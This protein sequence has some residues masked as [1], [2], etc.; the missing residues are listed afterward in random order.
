MRI[1]KPGGSLTLCCVLLGLG[2]TAA[3][4]AEAPAAMHDDGPA[5]SRPISGEVPSDLDALAAK[6]WRPEWA[7]LPMLRGDAAAVPY[8]HELLSS[9]DGQARARSAFLLGQIGSRNS[10]K[11]LAERLGDPDRDVRVQSGIAL[12][13]M[14]DARG[15]PV[16]AAALNTDVPWVRYY[17]AFGLWC[18]NT[19]RA[20]D[21]L[22]SVPSGHDELVNHAVQGALN[23][24]YV[25]PSVTPLP[26][27]A[28]PPPELSASDIW[29]QVADV[30]IRESD[31]W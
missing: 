14:G 7:P 9:P 15:I 20:Q 5:L 29:E 31:W 1:T 10:A 16:C 22:R 23:T 21:I 13:C 18:V 24:P 26:P 28:K 2:M 6:P 17:A 25:P 8:L 11:P 3:C 19:R 27:D 4:A 30:F 12:A